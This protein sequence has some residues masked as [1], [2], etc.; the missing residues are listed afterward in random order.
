M[1]SPVLPRGPV[2]AA[3]SLPLGAAAKAGQV[4]RG[5]AGFSSALLRCFFVS[6]LLS[7]LPDRLCSQKGKAGGLQLGGKRTNY[8]HGTAENR[9]HSG[10]W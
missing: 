3:A 4:Q 7:P 8:A 2:L 9:T 5:C 1:G 10:Q 6:A